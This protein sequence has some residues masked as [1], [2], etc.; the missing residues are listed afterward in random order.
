MARDGKSN[1]ARI[2]RPSA[3]SAQASQAKLEEIRRL[4][5]TQRL[6]LAL[7]LSDTCHELQ[8]ACS[9]KR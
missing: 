7:E 8:R 5:P 1:I 2:R 4:S 9:P 6:L 3:L